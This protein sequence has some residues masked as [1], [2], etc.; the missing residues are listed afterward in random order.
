MAANH[1]RSQSGKYTLSSTTQHNVFLASAQF[2]F[3]LDKNGHPKCSSNLHN[4]KTTRFT[5]SPSKR[6][7]P[8][9]SPLTT[10]SNILQRQQ[11]CTALPKPLYWRTFPTGFSTSNAPTMRC[12]TRRR[13]R[14]SASTFQ[15]HASPYH[16]PGWPRRLS[17][18]TTRR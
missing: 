5:S 14:R 17:M 18:R 11:P 9:Q 12:V 13:P 1:P 7:T 6:V 10:Q 15:S 3:R 8:Q 4:N 2:L 16:R